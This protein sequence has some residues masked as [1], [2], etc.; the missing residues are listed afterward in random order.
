MSHRRAGRPSKNSRKS[1]SPRPATAP[2]P[3]AHA[4]RPPDDGPSTLEIPGETSP[5]PP[6]ALV[7]WQTFEEPLE[8]ALP[9][10][11]G[12]SQAPFAPPQS[13]S[14]VSMRIPVGSI[15]LSPAQLKQLRPG[16]ILTLDQRIDE[17]V[18]IWIDH[19]PAARGTLLQRDGSC[20]V[21]IDEPLSGCSPADMPSSH[22]GPS[23]AR[24]A[25]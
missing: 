14:P 2:S 21:R 10:Q 17:P 24:K 15:S 19:L 7:D 12:F 22:A 20:T 5:S 11:A 23:A 18:V 1:L 13:E 25:A 6:L 9:P 16:T 4:S 8:P 3:T